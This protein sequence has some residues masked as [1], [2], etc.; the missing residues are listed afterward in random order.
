M[1]KQMSGMYLGEVGRRLLEELMTRAGL[2]AACGGAVAKA[3]RTPG[4]LTTA[5][6][7]AIEGDSSLTLSKTASALKEAFGV[8]SSTW[9]ERR[10][11]RSVCHLVALR[12]ARLLAV[13]ISALL[14]QAGRAKPGDASAGL[15]TAVAVDG[16]VYEHWGAYRSFV[17]AGLA[18][19]LGSAAAG[20]RV[21]MKRVRDAS[22][23]GAAY[24]AAAAA[25]V[26]GVEREVGVAQ[27]AHAL[28]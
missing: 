14:I 24:L 7:S 22:S 15:E 26:V 8:E 28:A 9:L 20:R 17:A 27:P 11:V 4:T 13:A 5:A 1:E 6:L 2:F 19:A 10:V 3:L 18:D 25:S 21:R 23:M 12:S 16:G